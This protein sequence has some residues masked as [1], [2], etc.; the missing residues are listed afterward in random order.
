[1]RSCRCVPKCK[2]KS[3]GHILPLIPSNASSVPPPSL[4]ACHLSPH[5]R[6]A[7]TID[8]HLSNSPWLS[9][10][11]SLNHHQKKGYRGNS[12]QQINICLVNS[13]TAIKDTIMLM[14]K[15]L[16]ETIYTAEEAVCTKT[17][18]IDKN[19]IYFGLWNTLKYVMFL[20]GWG[21]SKRRKEKH[22]IV[23]TQPNPY[24]MHSMYE[25]SSFQ[26]LSISN[27]PCL[28]TLSPRLSQPEPWTLQSLGNIRLVSIFLS[29]LQYKMLSVSMLWLYITLN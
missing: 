15:A 6:A 21:F 13:L 24:S 1:M 5:S 2:V 23:M 16:M 4:A 11:R 8:L 9:L 7:N 3:T 25:V 28:H 14:I 18:W 17:M 26:A 29:I 20:L 22:L 12:Q 10:S 19:L 27:L